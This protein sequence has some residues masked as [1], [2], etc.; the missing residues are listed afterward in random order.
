MAKRNLGFIYFNKKI[1]IYKKELRKNKLK[2]IE[3]NFDFFIAGS[4]QIWNPNFFTNMSINM[5]SFAKSNKKIAIAPSIGVVKLTDNQKNIFKKY[6]NDFKL[7][8]CREEQGSKIIKETTGRECPTLIDPTLMLS[9]EEWSLI[10][11]NQNFMMIQKN[12]FSYIFWEPSHKIITN[13]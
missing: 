12:L 2:K 13:L 11:K 4:D 3:K 10:E 1:K 7:L 8:S 6:L 9:K 5:L